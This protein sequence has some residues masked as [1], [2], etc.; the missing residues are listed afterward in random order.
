MNNIHEALDST[1]K[2]ESKL[3]KEVARLTKQLQDDLDQHTQDL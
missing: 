2:H 3:Q 1:K